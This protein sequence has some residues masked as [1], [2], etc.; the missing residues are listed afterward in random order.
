MTPSRMR[1]PRVRRSR[2]A[3]GAATSRAIRRAG[4]GAQLDATP[5]WVGVWCSSGAPVPPCWAAGVSGRRA[6]RGRALASCRRSARH[7]DLL[8]R[9]A[10][11]RRAEDPE[12]VAQA[13]SPPVEP[14]LAHRAGADSS[15]ATGIAG[16]SGPA[17]G[18]PPLPEADR[19]RLALRPVLTRRDIGF[20]RGGGPVIPRE[21]RPVLRQMQGFCDPLPASCGYFVRV[22]LF[23]TWRGGTRAKHVRWVGDLPPERGR[24]QDAACRRPYGGSPLC[25]GCLACTGEQG[26]PSRSSGP[27]L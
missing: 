15:P 17:A 4:P 11:P 9:S 25:G 20:P 26:R 8:Q 7:D 13:Q 5:P 18:A 21:S 14:G 16:T 2:R 3:K 27:S 23:T 24:Y 12:R 22:S 10:L 19:L 1:A 6:K